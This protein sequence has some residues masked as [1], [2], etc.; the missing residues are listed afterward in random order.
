MMLF[1]R[2][3]MVAG[4][5][6]MGLAGCNTMEGLGEDIESAGQA[7]EHTAENVRE[8]KSHHHY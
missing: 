1:L 7:L 8:D 4:M 5:F 3:I 6:F 2:K